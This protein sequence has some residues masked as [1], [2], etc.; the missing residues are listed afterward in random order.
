MNLQERKAR[1]IAKGEHS[2][3][4]H[5]LIGGKIE[6][7]SNNEI[8]IKVDNQ[9]AILKH[10]LE[11]EWLKGNEIWTKEHKDIKIKKGTY[12]FIQQKEYN[13]FDKIIEKVID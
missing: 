6:R 12:K 9:E 3:H 5:V 2:N 1:I 10:L 13:P 11:T 8:I 7:N 4:C